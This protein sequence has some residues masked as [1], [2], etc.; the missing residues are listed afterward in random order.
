MRKK[1][2]KPEANMRNACTNSKKMASAPSLNVRLLGLSMLSLPS[3]KRVREDMLPKED[4]CPLCVPGRLGLSG[5]EEDEAYAM[6]RYA[7]DPV[8]DSGRSL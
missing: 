4:V 7:F 5:P 1:V 6:T 2:R 8:R 3:Y